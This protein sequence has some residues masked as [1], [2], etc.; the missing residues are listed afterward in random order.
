MPP[1]SKTRGLVPWK[2]GQ[3]GNPKGRPPIGMSFAER[4]R[5]VTGQD[6]NKLIEMWS[7]IAWGRLPKDDP[8]ASS[9]VLYLESL[10]ALQRG[11]EIRDRIACS[12]LLAERGFGMPKQE[13]EHTGTVSLP[14]T[15]IHE[16]HSS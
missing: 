13:L 10:K 8:K 2:K 15:V 7:A 16:Y 12:K 1:S 9:S 4:V 3:S 5:A 6:G 14:T 11:A